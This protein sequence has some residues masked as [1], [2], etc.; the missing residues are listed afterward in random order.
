MNER[1]LLRKPLKKLL[2]VNWSKFG[3]VSMKINGSTL[4]TGVNG[5]GK[6]TILDAMTYLITGNT[7]FN[8]AAQDRERTVL[9]YVRGDTKSHGEYRYLRSGE[10]VSYIVMEFYSPTDRSNFVVGVC[11]E[12][13]DEQSQ[14]PYWFASILKAPPA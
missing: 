4:F 13:Q 1:K 6:S 8:T 7:Q 10:V 2:L 5:S 14:K 12:S 11:I 9:R 3:A